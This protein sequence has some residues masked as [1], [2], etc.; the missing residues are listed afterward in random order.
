MTNKIAII[1]DRAA[2]SDDQVRCHFTHKYHVVANDSCES[3]HNH[4]SL[5]MSIKCM[6]PFTKL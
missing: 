2:D 5:K 6:W 4:E 3:S 1:A